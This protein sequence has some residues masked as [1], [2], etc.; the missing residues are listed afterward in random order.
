MLLQHW[1]N[2]ADVEPMLQQHWADGLYQISVQ[3]AHLSRE[4]SPPKAGGLFT[5]GSTPVFTHGTQAGVI[6]ER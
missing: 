2:V 3:A 5:R 1:F 4:R 6:A